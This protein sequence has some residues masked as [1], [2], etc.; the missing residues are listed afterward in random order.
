MDFIL[1][2]SLHAL[3]ETLQSATSEPEKEEGHRGDRKKRIL[4]LWTR[5][6]HNG[7]APA[8]T[9]TRPPPPLALVG[10]TQAS[11]TGESHAHHALPPVTNSLSWQ[12]V[13]PQA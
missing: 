6:Q 5:P 11:L 12:T 4:T 10:A 9:R 8:D 13:S 1:T 3:Q 2:V 7:H